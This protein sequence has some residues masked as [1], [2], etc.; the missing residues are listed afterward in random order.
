MD[1]FQVWPAMKIVHYFRIFLARISHL[2]VINDWTALWT[3]V[4]IHKRLSFASLLR[5]MIL[6][7]LSY[8]AQHMPRLRKYHPPFWILVVNYWIL[9]L[10]LLFKHPHSHDCGE[11]LL[12]PTL[13]LQL[14]T[15]LYLLLKL[16]Q[17][18]KETYLTVNRRF[19]H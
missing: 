3:L 15:V 5:S 12:L 6:I 9:S 8:L 14:I 10:L 19:I 1:L 18:S 13:T 16:F 7:V 2:I 4:F 17:R 11:V